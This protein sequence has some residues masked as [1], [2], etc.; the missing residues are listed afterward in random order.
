M[1]KSS[2]SECDAWFEKLPPNTRP[3]CERL[4]AIIHRTAPDLEE[5]MRWGMVA[6]KGQGLVICIG[7]FKKHVN[8]LFFRGAELEDP[9]GLFQRQRDDSS[10]SNCGVRLEDPSQIQEAPLRDMVRRAAHLDANVAPLPKPKTKRQALPMPAALKKALAK[11]KAARQAFEKLA[12]SHQREYNEWI[13]GA[14]QEET[15]Q[16]RVE[17]TLAKL[18][19]GEGLNDK[20]RK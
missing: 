6:Y 18:A 17:K 8:L 1:P 3:I 16:R 19:A 20:Y 13:G 12:P 5:V 14:K 7:G 11:N 9:R 2:A 10:A 4:R 15:I